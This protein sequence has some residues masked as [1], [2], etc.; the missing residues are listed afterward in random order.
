MNTIHCPCGNEKPYS[1]CCE[2]FHNGLLPQTPEQLMRSRFSAFYL[3]NAPYLM[4][5]LHD[6][7]KKGETLKSL[8]DNFKAIHWK[9]LMILK[10]PSTDSNT[11]TVD[12]CAHFLE[13]DRYGQHVER[14]TFTKVNGK[15]L[16]HAAKILNPIKLGRNDVCF[17]GS[18]KKMKKCHPD[19]IA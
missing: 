9:T 1:Q 12:F 14:S 3:K 6:D 5:T 19:G 13:G 15:W 11:G 8:E 16:Y 18:K 7:L 10:A 17:C 2:I 4:D